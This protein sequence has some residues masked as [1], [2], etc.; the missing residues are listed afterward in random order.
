MDSIVEFLIE[1][2]KL[3]SVYRKSYLTDLTRNESSAEHSWHL[4]LA[5]LVMGEEVSS[6]FD[7]EH[8]LKIALV[9]DICEIGAGDVSVYSEERESI[10]Q[11]ERS[12]VESL[13]TEEV[14]FSREI[15]EL[16]EEYEAQETVESRCVRVL[17]RFLPFIINLHS[18][19]KTW[20]DQKVSK[21]DVIAINREI[22]TEAPDIF[23]WMRSRIDEAVEKGWLISS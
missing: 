15:N 7:L 21:N 10:K 5:L 17:D 18:E 9:H 13:V 8:A 3:K 2:D 11:G 14:P 4:A 20:Q 1:L 23:A 19:G 6:D 22:E 16:W 12:Y